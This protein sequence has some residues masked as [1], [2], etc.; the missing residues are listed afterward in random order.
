MLCCQCMLPAGDF[1]LHAGVCAMYIREFLPMLPWAA[2]GHRQAPGM[3]VWET[4]VA[5][6]SKDCLKH[7]IAS[8][9]MNH[10]ALLTNLMNAQL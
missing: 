4:T 2:C 10:S 5:C 3:E 9:C 7:L 8:W 1:Y 6:I